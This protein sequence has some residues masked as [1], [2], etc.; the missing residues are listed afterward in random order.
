MPE[1]RP[2]TTEERTANLTLTLGELGRK[3]TAR[4]SL[5][6]A[7]TPRQLPPLAFAG[8]GQVWAG[9]G[10][11]TELQGL[12]RTQADATT[13]PWISGHSVG[14]LQ[15]PCSSSGPE[16]ATFRH[17][18]GR[19]TCPSS[20]G[21]STAWPTFPPP[22][23]R[24]GHVLPQKSTA[25]PPLLLPHASRERQCVAALLRRPLD[26]PHQRRLA[27]LL[28]RHVMELHP[29]LTDSTSLGAGPRNLHFSK[30]FL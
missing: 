9:E 25:R 12:P 10:Q 8:A 19:P 29:G 6:E 17:N 3:K 30:F 14:W 20:L 1:W 18:L 15:C 13:R 28:K 7:R 11:R 22:D 16:S 24:R 2:C 23:V 21:Q 27:S 5:E 4:P 26:L